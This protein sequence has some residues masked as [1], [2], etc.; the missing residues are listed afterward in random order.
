M[1]DAVGPRPWLNNGWPSMSRAP[2]LT[3][4]GFAS[5]LAQAVDNAVTVLGVDS[6]GLMLL[7]EHDALRAVGYT[8]GG[9]SV[10]EAAQARIGQG[11]GI[12]TVREGATVAVPDLATTPAYAELWA[13]VSKTPIRAVLSCP[14]KAGGSV[15]GNL[16][17]ARYRPHEWAAEELQEIEAYSRVIGL[18]LKLAAE[19][20]SVA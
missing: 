11:P 4:P 6:V 5:R 1:A 13:S 12:D 17:A 20:T 14:V 7:D 18:T 3:G 10:L 16:N 8:D 19:A 9:S 15:V 2:E